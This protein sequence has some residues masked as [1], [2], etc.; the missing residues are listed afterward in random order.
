M[1]EATGELNM[2]VITLVAITAIAAVFYFVVW[3]LVQQTLV[4]QTC[5]TTYGTD[6]HAVKGTD[7]IGDTGSQA[8]VSTWACCNDSNK[9]YNSTT[10]EEMTG[11]GGSSEG[12]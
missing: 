8:E 10:G 5:K 7:V 11:N 1:K 9:C 4:N 3:P 12:N 6:Y 2:T